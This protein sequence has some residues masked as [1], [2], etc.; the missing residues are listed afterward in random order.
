MT[1]NNIIMPEFAEV[2]L[3][4]NF[5]NKYIASD[6]VNVFDF[7]T[8]ELNT[9]NEDLKPHFGDWI[10]S[11][12]YAKSRG[13]NLK[14]VFKKSA[15]QKIQKKTIIFSLGM[16]GLFFYI[17][18]NYDMSPMNKNVIFKCDV[19]VDKSL[20]IMDQR[21]FAKWKV[22]DNEYYWDPNRGPDPLD[23]WELFLENFYK[24]YKNNKEYLFQALLDQSIFN[25]VGNY[26]RAEILFRANINPF[27]MLNQLDETETETLLST[28]KECL[29]CSYAI[30]KSLDNKNDWFNSWLKCYQ[31][32]EF[33]DWKGRKFWFDSKW[34][35]FVPV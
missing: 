19:G 20:I 35:S 3:N 18:K 33:I 32:R 16:T 25:G 28:T 22:Y 4:A 30:L 7:S 15:T 31:K 27:K 11:L 8:L 14:M 34:Q 21:K 24:N 1:F 5:L 12:D 10:W 13:K 9:K 6:Q 2:R 26:L 17:D 29:I 23:E